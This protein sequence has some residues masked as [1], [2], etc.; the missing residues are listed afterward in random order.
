[1]FKL[2]DKSQHTDMS[3]L[4]L[5]RSYIWGTLYTQG[6]EIC[7]QD[8]RVH[9]EIWNESVIVQARHEKQNSVFQCCT[10]Q[11]TDRNQTW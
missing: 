5:F 8:Y 10:M 6:T 9:P 1:M 7:G 11:I 4:V 2:N 3:Y